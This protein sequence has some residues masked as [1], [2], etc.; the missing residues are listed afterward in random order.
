VAVE[1]ATR[2]PPPEEDDSESGI[3]FPS[4]PKPSRFV[5]S[6]SECGV[7]FDLLPGVSGLYL[8]VRAASQTSGIPIKRKNNSSR[9][10]GAYF[11]YQFLANV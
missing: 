2:Q 6:I 10:V 7:F 9:L 11:L 1:V 3:D 4:A 5:D 8:V